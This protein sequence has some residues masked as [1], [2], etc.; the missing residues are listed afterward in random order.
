MCH[1]HTFLQHVMLLWLQLSA[2]H[3]HILMLVCRG[4]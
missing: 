2:Q 1:I 4:Q 3:V